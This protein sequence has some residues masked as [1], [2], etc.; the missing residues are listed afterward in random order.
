MNHSDDCVPEG[1]QDMSHMM[2]D[3]GSERPTERCRECRQ[4]EGRHKMD[5]ST[6]RTYTP[7]PGDW[8]GMCCGHPLTLMGEPNTSY[9]WECSERCRCLI[10]GCVPNYERA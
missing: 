8:T 4:R 5:C 2:N 1:I 3:G 7:S 6:G 10:G 9:Y